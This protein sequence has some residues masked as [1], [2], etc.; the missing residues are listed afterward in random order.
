VDLVLAAREENN[1]PVDPT[2]K[3][4]DG[5]E[6]VYA[7]LT[8]DGMARNVPWT[9]VWYVKADG[10]MREVWSQVEL[11]TYDTSQGFTWRYLSS[12]NGQYELHIYIDRRLQQK[13]PFTVGAE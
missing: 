11:W 4:P 5:T 9:H 1:Q 8:F 3:F 6:R 12:Q 7:F 2:T 10:A 13:V